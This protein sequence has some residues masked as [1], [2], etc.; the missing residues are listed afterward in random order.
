MLKA[1]IVNYLGCTGCRICEL[2]CSVKNEG[3]FSAQLSRIRVYP[4]PPGLD[5]PVVCV[6]CD[7][8]PC[9]E[10][11]PLGLLSRDPGSGSVVIQDELCNGCG[12]CVGACPIQ[13]IFM[14][15]T[16]HVA[17]NCHLCQGEPDERIWN[18]TRMFNICEGF[19]RKDDALPRRILTEPL[20]SGIAKGKRLT[21]TQ[22][23]QMLDE[24]YTLRGWNI[25]TGTPSKEKL[26]ELKLNFATL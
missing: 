9:I 11:C 4:F 19:S 20:S 2:V 8:A 25:P 10:A 15:S 13:A 23:D 24:C 21:Q 3:V 14:H 7:K 18:L 22:L 6:Q 5:V 12:S 17:I 26:R 16:R 1:V